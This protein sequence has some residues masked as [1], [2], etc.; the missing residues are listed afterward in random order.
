MSQ[1]KKDHFL[2]DP[3]V[4]LVVHVLR[5]NVSVELRL[6]DP[7]PRAT[8]HGGLPPEGSNWRL[9]MLNST[10]R[11]NS[12]AGSGLLDV[13]PEH[14]FLGDGNRK[15]PFLPHFDLTFF[16]FARVIGITP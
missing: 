13:A 11:Q 4:R 15:L 9:N 5:T 7:L 6:L 1:K 2:T 3:N 8:R 10:E 14:A 12:L 16:V